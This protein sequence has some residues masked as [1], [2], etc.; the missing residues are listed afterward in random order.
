[1][2]TLYDHWN[3]YLEPLGVKLSR[4]G[5][6]NRK[7]LEFLYQKLNQW[8]SKE[9]II[10]S[11]GYDGNDLQAPRHLSREGWFI[12][13]DNKANYKL[14]SV[15][16]TYPNW[17]P[18]KRKTNISTNSFEELKQKYNYE[19]ATCG[20]KENKPHR[21]TGKIV[22]IEKGHKDPDKDLTLDNIIPQ[23]NYCNKRF[24]DTYKF[25]NYGI[26]IEIRLNGVWQKIP[27]YNR[28]K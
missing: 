26:P 3:E 11:I 18:D 27:N 23:C 16:K 4:E 12:E 2:I 7:T 5:S 17:I 9:E 22:K 20:S 19:C 25:D 15:K 28:E 21:H 6:W 13:Q 8:I 24:K 10:G 14:V 1:M